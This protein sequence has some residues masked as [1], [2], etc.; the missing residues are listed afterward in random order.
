M[1][2]ELFEHYQPL[3]GPDEMF[4]RDGSIRPAYRAFAARLGHWDV[5]EYHLR[6]SRA[7]LALLN[8]GITFTVYSDDQGT[9]RIFPF[10][11]IPRIIGSREWAHIEAG[12]SQRVRALNLFLLD[13]YNEQRSIRDNVVPAE[14]VFGGPEYNLRMVGFEPPLGVYA[15]IS[16]V[17]LVRNQDGQFVVL[18]DNLRTPSGVSYVLENRTVM[19]RVAPDVFPPHGVAPVNDYPSRLLATLIDVRP[20]QISEADCRVVILTP[21]IF[22]SAYFEHA[23]LAQQMGVPLVE[24]V[25]LVTHNERVYLR[26][27][28]GLEPVHVVYRRVDDAFLDPLAFRPDST[29]GVTGLMSAYRAGNITVAN[30][31]GTGIADD[32]VVYRFVPDIIRYFLNE[33]PLLPNV[34]TYAAVVPEEHEFIKQHA[35]ELVLKPANASGGYG[36]LIGP[37]ASDDRIN[38][39]LAA[40]EAEPRQWIAQPLQEFSTIPTFQDD[41]LGARRADLRPYVLTGASTW[42]LP[43]A[44]TRVALREGSYV[45]NSSQGGGSKDTWVL[46]DDEDMDDVAAAPGGAS[47]QS[48]TQRSDAR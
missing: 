19:V 4:E 21:G 25:D 38:E 1:P 44:L 36:V 46:T 22:N 39:T 31:V 43:S 28:S 3:A 32:K 7:D 13:I 9:E 8:A 16:G 29:L 33:E 45:V 42:V 27:T 17:D 24:G 14:I 30:A 34:E 6:Q 35:R 5:A 23:F 20:P 11:L 40:I 10:S 47:S 12:L 41:K 15:H 37:Q 26:S 2:G 48:Q 18:E